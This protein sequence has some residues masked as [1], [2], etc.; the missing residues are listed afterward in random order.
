[1]DEVRASAKQVVECADLSP[2]KC[3]ES[4]DYIRW[5]L[6]TT[7]HIT[8]GNLLEMHKCCRYVFI[9]GLWQ[10][11]WR[12]TLSSGINRLSVKTLTGVFASMYSSEL[13]CLHES[14]QFN[15]AEYDTI[16]PLQLCAYT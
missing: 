11:H 13:H 6:Q 14:K 1:M 16:T 10:T 3:M 5:V 15:A 4:G 7:N 2:S 9:K 8:Y 12:N